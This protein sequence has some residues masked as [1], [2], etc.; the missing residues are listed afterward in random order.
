MPDIPVVDQNPRV[1]VAASGGQ[2]QFSYNFFIG[3]AS[4]LSVIETKPTGF[5]KLVQG[6]D[7]TVTSG[8]GSN[9]GGQITLDPTAY[10]SGATAGDLY[11]LFR[12]IPIERPAD[13]PFRGPFDSP[14][15][16]VD[17]DTLYL[18]QQERRRDIDRALALPFDD[19]LQSVELPRDRANKALQ[20]D[21]AGAPIAVEPTDASGTSVTAT[22]STTSRQ[23]AERWADIAHSKDYSVSAANP[24]NADHLQTW[25]NRFASIT[26]GGPNRL[27]LNAN[28]GDLLVR[29]D[30]CALEN[31]N[32][33]VIY[34]DGQGFAG[35]LKL[36][37]GQTGPLLKLGG[38]T[39]GGDEP[40]DFLVESLSLHGNG[41]TLT[42]GLLQLGK[43]NRGEFRH[44]GCHGWGQGAAIANLAFGNSSLFNNMAFTEGHVVG[45]GITTATFG[46]DLKLTGS[47]KFTSGSAENVGTG[48]RLVSVQGNGAAY[49]EGI[50]IERATIALD[51]KDV[52]CIG[53]LHNKNGVIRLRQGCVG[54]QLVNGPGY[55]AG[56]NTSVVDENFGNA[57]Y[58]RGALTPGA[59][60]GAVTTPTLVFDGK[61]LL[62]T[63]SA[64]ADP[65][66]RD[67]ELNDWSAT[68]ATLTSSP[69]SLP[70]ARGRSLA[71]T[72]SA[73]NGYAETTVYA[74]ESSDYLLTVGIA[75]TAAANASARIEVIDPSGPTTLWDSGALDYSADLGAGDNTL[76]RFVRKRIPVP[77]G[78]AG[79]K[80]L[81]VR[82][83]SVVNGTTVQ[84]P[85]FLFLKSIWN[86]ETDFSGADASL[87]GS[88]VGAQITNAS[89]SNTEF[90]IRNLNAIHRHAAGAVFHVQID[91]VANGGNYTIGFFGD[92]NAKDAGPLLSSGAYAAGEEFNFLSGSYPKFGQIRFRDFTGGDI[93]ISEASMHLIGDTEWGLISTTEDTALSATTTRRVAVAPFHNNLI[94]G[95]VRLSVGTAIAASGVNYWTAEVLRR[96]GAT[97]AVVA[98][99]DSQSGWTADTAI[100][101]P[102]QNRTVEPD[103][104]IKVRYT[105]TGTPANLEPGL[106]MRFGWDA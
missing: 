82:L 93:T 23:L 100:T 46:Y 91:A 7:Y 49:F 32:S 61:E 50:S 15:V 66:F 47:I 59:G 95:S 75:V 28:A 31:F 8:I 101:I 26:A 25:L 45:P 39:A 14:V 106:S 65:T 90:A 63:L 56:E 86:M 58:Q 20:F 94:D 88:G 33:G 97:E 84:Y 12:E 21:G 55:G 5:R 48:I 38:L 27:H 80:S 74:D 70:N 98:T 67:F 42:S 72:A 43:M 16:N 9:Q 24:D 40:F 3:T 54:S 4:Q 77:A 81:T 68:N 92:S 78:A 60:G 13:Y 89:V 18:A 44:V 103:D 76:F 17:F 2:T 51:A 69:I 30:F 87:V 53:T 41:N 79:T 57:F 6:V 1:Q 99:A 19:P 34:G 102:I 10:P 37:T 52:Q 22:G 105:R 73:A 62:R 85:L 71:V 83:Y 64:V 104:I 29:G 11:T 36:I 96:R 35:R